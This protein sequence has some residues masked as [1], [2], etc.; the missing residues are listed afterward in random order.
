MLRPLYLGRQ[1]QLPLKMICNIAGLAKP[2]IRENIIEKLGL[3]KKSRTVDSLPMRAIATRYF[4]F[5]LPIVEKK[6]RN[7]KNQL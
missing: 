4:R 6:S 3:F 7:L 5:E 1:D 2:E